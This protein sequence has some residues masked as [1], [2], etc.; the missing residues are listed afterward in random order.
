MPLID[1]ANAIVL[2]D[3]LGTSHLVVAAQIVRVTQ[4]DDGSI[5]VGLTSGFVHVPKD[6]TL[7]QLS[8]AIFGVPAAQIAK[9]IQSPSQLAGAVSLNNVVPV[10]VG[11]A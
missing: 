10:E 9:P 4:A 2:V 6:T 8:L 7:D 1:P 11:A 5:G 3:N